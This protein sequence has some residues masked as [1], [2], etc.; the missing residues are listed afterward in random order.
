ML[1]IVYTDLNTLE[2]N[3]IPYVLFKMYSIISL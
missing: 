1:L 3:K 2:L